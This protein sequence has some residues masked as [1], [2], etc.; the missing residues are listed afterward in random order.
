MLLRQL[1]Q[2]A[3]YLIS[4]P[5]ARVLISESITTK[6][7]VIYISRTKQAL[8]WTERHPLLADIRTRYL[9]SRLSHNSLSHGPRPTTPLQQP[10]LLRPRKLQSS[11]LIP[12]QRHL[13][14]LQPPLPAPSGKNSALTTHTPLNMH[15]GPTVLNSLPTNRGIPGNLSHKP[16]LRMGERNLLRTGN[17]HAAH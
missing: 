4:F 11:I 8:K 7:N 17:R 15:T 14:L 2:A 6:L 1:S 9:D 3:R 12:F 10:P 16:R 5:F 13:V